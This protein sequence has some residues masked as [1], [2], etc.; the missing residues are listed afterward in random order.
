MPCCVH[1]HAPDFVLLFQRK[2]AGGAHEHEDDCIHGH[3]GGA[4]DP[5]LSG[6][7]SVSLQQGWQGVLL[8]FL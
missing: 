3:R 2:K 5:A 6:L 7:D 8:M 1:V 4:F